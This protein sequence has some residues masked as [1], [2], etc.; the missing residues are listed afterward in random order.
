MCDL[1]KKTTFFKHWSRD[2]G[3]KI[4]NLKGLMEF[5]GRLKD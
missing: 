3:E 4:C 1:F 5:K 2:Y